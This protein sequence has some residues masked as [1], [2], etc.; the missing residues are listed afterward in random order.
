MLP[1]LRCALLLIMLG[2]SAA[3]AGT[4]GKIAGRVIDAGNGQP[5][6]GAAVVL[7]GTTLGAST[8]LDG[9]YVI[10]NVPPGTYAVRVTSVGYSPTTIRSVVVSADLTTAV[11]CKLGEKA[12]QAQEVV[13]TAQQPFVQKDLTSTESRISGDQ[14]QTLPVEDVQ[15]VVDLQAGVVDGHFRGGRSGEVAYM[16]DGLSVND[17][18]SGGA[19]LQVENA[20]VQ[21]IQVISGTFNAEYGQAMSGVVNVITK[22]GGDRL[23]GQITSYAGSYWTSHTD[24]FWNTGKF[25]PSRIYNL[26]GVLSGPIL[27]LPGSSFFLNS[28]LYNND[29]YLYGQR[30]YRPGDSS[31]FSATPWRVQSTGDG[32][33][34]PM[35]PDRRWTLLGKLSLRLFGADKLNLSGLS[36][37]QFGRNYEHNFRLEPDGAYRNLRKSL[38]G[39]LE[40]THVFGESAFLTARGSYLTS[41]YR[42]F[43]FSDP[44][45]PRYIDPLRLQQ[46]PVDTFYTGGTEMWQYDREARS[47]GAKAD[48]TSQI[49]KQHLI[50]TG[51]EMRF[52]RMWRHDF[53]VRLDATTNYKP[54]LPPPDAPDNL[55]YLVRP[56]EAAAYV[57]DKMEFDYLIVNVGLR[58]DYFKP[59][60]VV[61]TNPDALPNSPFENATPKSQ[62]SPRVGLAY[63]ITDRGVIHLSYGEFFQIP[64]FE[65]LYEDPGFKVMVLGGVSTVHGNAD[66]KPQQTTAYEIGL[67]QQLTDD[68]G[69]DVTLYY[70]DIRNLIDTEIRDYLNGAAQYARYVNRDYGNVKGIVLSFDKRLSDNFTASIDYTY[71]I[72]RGNASDPLS[73]FLDNQTRPPRE[74][75]KSLVALNWDRTHSVNLSVSY[76]MS[77]NFDASLI[78]RAGSGLPYTPSQ[79]SYR[80]AGVNSENK[81]SFYNVDLAANKYFRIAG[82]RIA[83][84]VKV[85]NLFDALNELDVFGDTGRAGYTTSLITD[86]PPQGVNTLKE[87][88]TR[89]DF[90]SAPRQVL[91]G[92][93][94]TF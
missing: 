56:L 12:I 37:W 15:S 36:Q 40:F 51:I 58:Y 89:P 29:G 7:E 66:L 27:L 67:Q 26:E 46:R 33:Y 10:I 48:L 1:R 55:G 5:V 68:I 57:Q 77:D 9:G 3:T 59:T 79:A 25:A 11:D 83:V 22:E 42:Q 16:I 20:A 34:V 18:Y 62:L 74:S 53:Q 35:S 80:V 85:Y 69:M 30:I 94:V 6:I 52:H 14:I 49:T 28:R 54:E 87:Y 43:V 82:E 38:D 44:Y 13:V 47:I 71:Q 24:I 84:F 61:P 86:P 73:V 90:Y 93:S 63:P 92:M 32:A 45:D 70:K 23:S 88:F 39:A 8:D 4:R 75:P 72:A 50:K 21:E 65:F 19:A 41:L 76:V 60:S 2:V 17:A 81:P 78:G 91:V 64:P 31:N